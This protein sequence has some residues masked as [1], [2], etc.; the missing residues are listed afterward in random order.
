MPDSFK[1]LG[2]IFKRDPAFRNLR[3]IVKSADV[4]SDFYK[5]FPDFNK[6]AIA[7]KVDK[8]VLKL[9]VEN[10]AWRNEM[11][12]KEK[13]IVERINNFYKEERIKQIRFTS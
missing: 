6:I 13:E 3:E 11:K 7:Q 10:P 5:I 8:K 12:F 2:E 1:S 9:R 4:V